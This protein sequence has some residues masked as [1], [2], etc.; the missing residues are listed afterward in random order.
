MAQWL[1]QFCG[2]TPKKLCVSKGQFR[3]VKS[4]LP[5]QFDI[6]ALA[7]CMAPFAITEDSELA[8]NA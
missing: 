6:R 2:L 8:G 7:G 5:T 1:F 3:T 4:T